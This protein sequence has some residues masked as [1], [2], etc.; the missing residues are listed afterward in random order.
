MLVDGDASVR[1]C[2]P[3][4]DDEIITRTFYIRE[5]NIEE[6]VSR[7]KYIDECVE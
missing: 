4:R 5:K 3:L 7:E 1:L 6:M 2:V